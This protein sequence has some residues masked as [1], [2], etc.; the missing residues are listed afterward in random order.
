MHVPNRDLLES[1]VSTI[2]REVGETDREGIQD[3]PRRVADMYL[4][5]T[6]GLRTDPPKMVTFDARGM[7]QMITVLNLEYASM[8][9]HHLLPIYG[10]VHVGYVPRNRIAGLSKFGRVVDWLACRP[11]IQEA[12]TAQ[13]A[14]Y[15]FATLRPRGVIVVVEGSHLCMSI[16]G[17]KKQGHKTVTS[18]IRG[19]VPKDEFLDILKAQG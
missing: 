11:Q 3:T 15:V 16:R 8:C 18:A 14:D 6:S 7:D 13:L 9:E 12:M 17:V 1:A 4:E 2:L 10:R 5:M 19:D